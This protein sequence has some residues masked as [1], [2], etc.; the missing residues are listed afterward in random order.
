MKVKL[1]WKKCNIITKKYILEHEDPLIQTHLHSYS[2]KFWHMNFY[3]VLSILGERLAEKYRPS[4]VNDIC[5]TR[6][7]KAEPCIANNRHPKL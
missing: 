1:H 3:L 2:W 4:S 6:N 7:I 5:H